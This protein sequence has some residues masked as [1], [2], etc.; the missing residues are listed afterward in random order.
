MDLEYK[1]TTSA[2]LAGAQ[3]AADALER[4]IG[5]AKALKQD[6]SELDKQL[7]TI[8]GSI[9][10]YG[11]AEKKAAE[12]TEGFNIK[13]K[14]LLES[15]RH[16]RAEFPMLGEAIKMVF[17]PLV[18]GI[19]GIIGSFAI[20]KEKVNAVTEAM[21][22]IELPDLSGHIGQVEG[23]AASYD[24]VDKAIKNVDEEFGSAVSVFDRQQKAIN[25]SLNATKQLL[26]A[27]KQLAISQ[28]DVEKSSGKISGSEYDARKAVIEK[29]YSDQT[30]QVEINARNASLAAK[31]EELAKAEEQAAAK[32]AAAA[33][34]KLPTDDKDVDAQIAKVKELIAALQGQVDT[35]K[36]NI[37]KLDETKQGIMSDTLMENLA[38]LPSAIKTGYTF[39]SFR[40]EDAKGIEKTSLK[41]AQDRLTAALHLLADIERK[42]EART[43]ARAGAEK[44]SG[45]AEGLRLGIAG[46]EDP[47]RP[48]STAWLNAQQRGT[49]GMRDQA[50]DFSRL[51][52]DFTNIGK[53][54]G[55][56]RNFDAKNTFTVQEKN[57]AQGALKD[58]LKGIADA[59]NVIRD[60]AAAGKDIKASLQELEKMKAEVAQLRIAVD[61]R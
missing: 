47:T 39:G 46:E 50:S 36:A 60:L 34:I 11:G 21:G 45:T 54:I 51:A 8:R 40:M 17:N 35:H 10:E 27:Q 14:E 30:M 5:K 48:G 57:E 61:T 25:A 59:T 4:Q 15:V 33:G 16:L 29:G 55:V 53:D 7:K 58:A 22:G 6:Y 3:A 18:F 32:K 26:D 20:W 42:K 19:G 49:Q 23:L 56:A 37:S 13:K 9:D 12:E 31:K 24:G 28:L 2:E 52:G 43:A 44:A 38:A 41:D 1:I